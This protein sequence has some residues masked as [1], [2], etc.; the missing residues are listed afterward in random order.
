MAENQRYYVLVPAKS[1]K[2]LEREAKAVSALSSAKVGFIFGLIGII[3][4]F[5]GGILSSFPVIGSIISL[6]RSF[7]FVYFIV[8]IINS[9]IG[10]AKCKKAKGHPKAKKAKGLAIA[11]LI[12]GIIG[13]VF[14]IVKIIII[15]CCILFGIGVVIFLIVGGAAMVSSIASE[16]GATGLALLIALL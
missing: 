8:A 7:T 10:L 13:I 15:I 9:A 4:E 1:R 12:F 6:A 3:L 16:A 14:I 11:G 2:D 5:L